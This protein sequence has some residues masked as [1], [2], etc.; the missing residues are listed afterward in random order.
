MII[1]KKVI[2]ARRSEN[3]HL[4]GH[5]TMADVVEEASRVPYECSYNRVATDAGQ[6]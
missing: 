6:S 4:E 3:H 2:V 1:E 5:E